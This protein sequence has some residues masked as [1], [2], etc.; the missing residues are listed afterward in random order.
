MIDLI[1][2]TYSQILKKIKKLNC[3]QSQEE[4]IN[5]F[6]D[7]LIFLYIPLKEEDIDILFNFLSNEN[8]KVVCVDIFELTQTWNDLIYQLKSHDTIG[9]NLYNLL[10]LYFNLNM[11][12][13]EKI[14][15][16]IHIKTNTYKTLEISTKN[17]S[18]N[19]I[20]GVYTNNDKLFEDQISLNN[21]VLKS[22]KNLQNNKK[23]IKKRTSFTKSIKFEV[24]KRDSYHCVAC[25]AGKEFHLEVDHIYPHSKGGSDELSNLQTLCRSCNLSKSDKIIEV[26]K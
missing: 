4:T 21:Y 22:L 19:I 18:E 26:R 10:K 1:K 7:D 20:I 13:S 5:F 2:P 8:K 6:Q 3:T 15:E 12:R 24:F 11:I 23:P 9:S 17:T 16:N 25:G 14:G